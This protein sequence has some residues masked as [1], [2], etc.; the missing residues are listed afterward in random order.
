MLALAGA[1]FD[2]DAMRAYCAGPTRGPE[3]ARLDGL[4]VAT[5]PDVADA[6]ADLRDA[7][8]R[9]V[10]ALAPVL[11]PAATAASLAAIRIPVLLVGSPADERA[12]FDANARAL[13]GRIP[14]ARLVTLAGAGHFAFL[15]ACNG[16]GRAF[17]RS[18]CAAGT[19]EADR[20]RVH[21]ETVAAV[22]R[23]LATALAAA[24]AS[25]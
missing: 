15:P 14:G 8:V 3:C 24:P 1:R 22:G 9:A 18:V 23:F 2:P 17:V 10:V 11:A 7:R 16:W 5:I 4:D 6:G 12:S 19:S 21:E 20:A 25:R 13:A